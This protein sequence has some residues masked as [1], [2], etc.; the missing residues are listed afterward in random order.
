VW[1][2]VGRATDYTLD[3]PLPGGQHSF[4]VKAVDKAGNKGA[5][6]LCRLDVDT[7][8]PTI[9][10][11]S[12]DRYTSRSCTISWIISHHGQCQVEYG[13]TTAYGM[14][15]STPLSNALFTFDNNYSVDLTGLTAN[16]T[17][18][19]RVKA[20]DWC[21]NEAVSED[22]TFATLP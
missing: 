6:L 12:S 13:T 19:Y 14:S 2:N 15:Q 18:H 22:H 10:N 9:C 7:T 20:A 21:G 11:V 17:Y 4:E 16:T 3:D 1:V 8:P 5:S